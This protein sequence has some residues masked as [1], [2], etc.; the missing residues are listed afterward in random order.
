MHSDR[1]YNVVISQ[2]TPTQDQIGHVVKCLEDTY[3]V[4]QT[5]ALNLLSSPLF[6]VDDGDAFVR[7]IYQNRKFCST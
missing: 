4:S 7:I 5:A 3:Q 6:T 1:L 2:L